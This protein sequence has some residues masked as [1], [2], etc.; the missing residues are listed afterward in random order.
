MDFVPAEQLDTAVFAAGCFWG[1]EYLFKKLPGVLLTQVGYTGGKLDNPK[2]EQVL[3]KNTG[4]LE[5]LLVVY[6]TKKIDYEALAKHFFEIHDP[7]QANGQG[8]DIGPQYLSAIFS[9]D[10]A[11]IAISQNL[12]ALLEGK[13]LKIATQILPSAT[14][15]PAEDYHQDFY[16]ENPM[17]PYNLA[18]IRPKLKKLDEKAT[19]LNQR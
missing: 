10:P 15:W 18:V 6:D 5:A 14:F 9:S 11:E 2:Y 13:G 12:I 4:H 17:H 3:Q 8:P 7:T 1:V 19:E 16:R